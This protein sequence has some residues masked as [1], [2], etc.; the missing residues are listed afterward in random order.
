MTKILTKVNSI[1][2]AINLIIGW[3][4]DGP[5]ADPKALK[6]FEEGL[7]EAFD[8]F[9][10]KSGTGS[11]NGRP[12]VASAY[13]ITASAR[14]G[15]LAVIDQLLI[16]H[17]AGLRNEWVHI[18]TQVVSVHHRQLNVA[19]PGQTGPFETG[20]TMAKQVGKRPRDDRTREQMVE[21]A[22]GRAVG[23]RGVPPVA[24]KKP[25]HFVG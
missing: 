9:F 10:C 18:D 21:A 11:W 8:G 7:A 3:P 20:D 24:S 23:I 4:Y 17:G 14:Q 25:G 19:D 13:Y 6:G 2:V 15:A 12:E 5:G 16:Q 22:F 1:E